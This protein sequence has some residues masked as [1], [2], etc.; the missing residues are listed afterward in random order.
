VFSPAEAIAICSRYIPNLE[1]KPQNFADLNLCSKNLS[2]ADQIS[3][4][5]ITKYM[6]N[7]LLR[8]SDMMSMANG[9]ELRVP[10]VDRVFLEAIA[11]IPSAMRLATGK[12]LLIQ[13]I[14]ELPDFVVN[15]PKQ[16]FAFPFEQWMNQEWSERFSLP[17][18]DNI[19]LT[20]WYR[21]WSLAMLNHWLENTVR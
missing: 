14:P 11:K 7:Q 21:R 4:L 12:Q 2:I 16:G 19:V 15:R 18:L 13:S 10:L 6:R 3:T 8:D 1:F 5:E 20:P 9:L 17:S